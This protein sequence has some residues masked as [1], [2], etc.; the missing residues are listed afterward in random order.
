M[1]RLLL[2]VLVLCISGA[3]QDDKDTFKV[4]VK[5]VSVFA[6]V[7]DS[8]GAPV[9]DL[10]K[11]QFNITEDGVPQ[12]VSVFEQESAVPLSIVLQIDASQSVHK[13]LKL[14]LDSARRFV[15]SVVRKQDRLALY[16]FNETVDELVPFTNDVQKISRG[17]SNVHIGAAT[18]MYD[19]IYLGGASLLDRQGRK[20]M[21]IITDG[22]DTVSKVRYA[23]ALR[24]AVQAEAIVY[25]IIMVP[26]TA[27]AGRDLGGEHALIQLA[28][29][30]GG[31]YYYADTL[32]ALDAAFQQVSKELRTQ[33]LLGYYPKQRLTNSDF[34]KIEVTVKG[35]EPATDAE[36]APFHVRHRTGYYTSKLY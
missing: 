9:V 31:K 14:E 3:A 8:R 30:T 4:N 27:S 26:I 5:L 33:Y 34:R 19:A 12:T 36:E 23:E 28:K 15:A 22:G 2:L 6:T 10:K 24:A 13:D 11:E 29:D 25:P 21:V 7:T 16:Q 1:R 35:N 17:I 32:P 18:A 20:V